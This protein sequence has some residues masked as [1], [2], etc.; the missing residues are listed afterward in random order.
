[1]AKVTHEMNDPWESTLPPPPFKPSICTGG[2]K[3]WKLLGVL[4]SFP[5]QAAAEFSFAISI[6]KGKS[7]PRPD[8]R[9]GAAFEA[10]DNRY[11]ETKSV[12][13]SLS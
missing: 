9:E 7:V 1:M 3:Q 2:C 6:L 11:P 8:A 4:L 5:G 13:L 10:Q 12:P